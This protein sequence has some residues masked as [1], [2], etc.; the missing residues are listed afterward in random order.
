MLLFGSSCRIGGLPEDVDRIIAGVTRRI[1]QTPPAAQESENA[2]ALIPIR[3]QKLHISFTRPPSVYLCL[4]TG[5]LYWH[6]S[7]CELNN[8]GTFGFPSNVSYTFLGIFLCM[9][10]PVLP[11]TMRFFY[12]ATNSFPQ[13]R[14]LS[15][16]GPKGPYGCTYRCYIATRSGTCQGRVI[17]QCQCHQ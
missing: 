9:A 11:H 16:T 5:V 2:Q 13:Q 7:T 3:M 17:C 12:V 1:S 10:I 4:D 6:S 14:R 15:P 8:L